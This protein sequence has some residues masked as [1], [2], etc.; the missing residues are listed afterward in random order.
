MK[1]IKQGRNRVLCLQVL[2]KKTK[3][4]VPIHINYFSPYKNKISKF[5]LQDECMYFTEWIIEFPVLNTYHLKWHWNIYRLT[6]LFVVRFIH[7]NMAARNLMIIE[8]NTNHGQSYNN[9]NHSMI[10]FRCFN[11]RIGYKYTSP[12]KL[13]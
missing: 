7:T 6:N 3:H 2:L 12:E 11:K 9:R 1:T 4:N 5:L 10:L 8:N 13:I